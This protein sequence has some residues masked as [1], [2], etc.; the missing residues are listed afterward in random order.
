MRKGFR[1]IPG[2]EHYAINKKGDVLSIRRNKILKQ[3]KTGGN[4][5][6]RYP[7]VCIHQ[8]ALYVHR[9][10]GITFIPNPDNKPEINH[11]DFNKENNSV[12]N[13]EW[14]THRENMQHYKKEKTNA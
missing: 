1:R 10:V 7:V 4:P 5:G 9:L 6:S 3:A 13:L 11:K 12:E 14:V 8:K 2:L